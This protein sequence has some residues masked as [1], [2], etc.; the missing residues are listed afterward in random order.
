MPLVSEGCHVWCRVDNLDGC[1]S[2]HSVSGQTGRQHRRTHHVASFNH[3]GL[4]CT[5]RHMIRIIRVLGRHQAIRSSADLH[6]GEDHMA[7]ETLCLP[8]MDD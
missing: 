3:T 2:K 4:T 6:D 7:A 5:I 8:K 1:L